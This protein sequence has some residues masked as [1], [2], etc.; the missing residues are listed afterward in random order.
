MRCGGNEARVGAKDRDFGPMI[1]P[2]E[3]MIC[4]TIGGAIASAYDCACEAR[5]REATMLCEPA[6][7]PPE[8]PKAVDETTSVRFEKLSEMGMHIW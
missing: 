5:R 7:Y 8:A 1:D 3:V 2:M 6:I 4:E